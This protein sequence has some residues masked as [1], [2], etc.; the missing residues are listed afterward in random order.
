[1]KTEIMLDWKKYP[2]DIPEND[3]KY[4]VTILVDWS[5]EMQRKVDEAFY[6]HKYLRWLKLDRKSRLGDAYPYHVIAYAK[7]EP[8]KYA[9]Y[10]G[11]INNNFHICSLCKGE[12]RRW[13]TE[14]N[15]TIKVGCYACNGTGYILSKDRNDNVCEAK[16]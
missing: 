16:P 14:N 10:N 6:S 2:D 3:G 9:P 8:P 5:G 13:V 15:K 1:M 11:D 7:N 12:G 4:F